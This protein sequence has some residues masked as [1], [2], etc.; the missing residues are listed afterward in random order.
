MPSQ[1]EKYA[2]FQ[3]KMV[4]F[5]I[6]FRTKTAKKT[7]PFEAAN[8]VGSRFSNPQFF[9]PPNNS[10]QKSF[11]SPQ[12]N[13][14]I[15]P[16]ISQTIKFFEPIFVS[17]GGSKNQNSTVYAKHGSRVLRTPLIRHTSTR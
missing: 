5:Y 2:I 1:S 17:R 11:P 10:N 6:L 3:A 15:L 7:I 9:E 8:T 16:S 14:V 4:K 12:S 13:T